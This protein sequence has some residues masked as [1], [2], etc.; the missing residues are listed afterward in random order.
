MA[1]EKWLFCVENELI[2]GNCGKL[3]QQGG[4]RSPRPSSYQLAAIRSNYPQHSTYEFSTVASGGA[5]FYK[6]TVLPLEGHLR[7]GGSGAQQG[8]SCQSCPC[9]LPRSPPQL[10]GHHPSGATHVLSALDTDLAFREA[11]VDNE[12][13]CARIHSHHLLGGGHLEHAHAVPRSQ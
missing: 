8:H 12:I 9:R 11:A 3:S 13:S 5:G 2:S 6:P 1:R 7:A 10:V 4:F